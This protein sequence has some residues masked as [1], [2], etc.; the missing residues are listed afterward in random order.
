MTCKYTLKNGQTIFM[1]ICERF[2]EVGKEICYRHREDKAIDPANKILRVLIDEITGK[3]YFVFEG[4]RIYF[5]DYDYL[6]IEEFIYM[7]KHGALT[8]GQINYQDFV[9]TLFKGCNNIGFVFFDDDHD[10][11]RGIYEPV[12]PEEGNISNWE[13]LIDLQ[14]GDTVEHFFTRDLFRLLCQ[15]EVKIVDSN[16]PLKDQPLERILR[17][18]KRT[19]IKPR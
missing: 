1:D 12:I 8:K 2:L 15:G 19:I 5:S 9:A 11:I 3:P 10:K 13:N 16:Q 14:N 17:R 7:A 4:E 18:A 6:S